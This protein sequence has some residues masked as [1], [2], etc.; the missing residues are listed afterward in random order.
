MGPNVSPGEGLERALRDVRLYGPER[1][2]AAQAAYAVL[3]DGSGE[4]T[5]RAVEAVVSWATR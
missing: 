3:P 2:A 4:A 1:E 5:R